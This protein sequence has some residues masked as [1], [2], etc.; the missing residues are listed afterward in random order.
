[1]RGGTFDI[2]RHE[3]GCS[4][5]RFLGYAGG[6]LAAGALSSSFAAETS[7]P[8]AA[9]AKPGGATEAGRSPLIWANLL[10]LS[11]N[12]WCDRPQESN[13]PHIIAIT[14]QPYLRCDDKLWEDLTQRM[15][16]AGMNMIVIDLGDGVRYES[17]PEIAVKGAWSVERLRQELAQLRKLGLEPI[18][19]LNFSTAHDAWLGVYS[20]QVSS[21]PYYKACEELIDEVIRLFDKPRFF[22][23]G[24]DEE[25]AG[26][27]SQYA[28]MI[29]RQH[30]LWW[31]D[32]DF[33]VKQ[34]EKRGARPWIWS[35]YIW[36]HAKDF[37]KQMPKSVLQSNW[38]YDVDFKEGSDLF[39]SY[40]QWFGKLDRSGYDQIPAGSNW[41]S[42]KSFG[43]LVE[44]CQKTIA[45][46]HL[47]GFLQTPWHPTLE[48]YRQQHIEAIDQV[49][50]AI[51]AYGKQ[52]R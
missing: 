30:E 23:L 51:A 39:K 47:K 24:Y 37:L 9:A 4:R 43:M 22:H 12:M 40:V 20:R 52:A 27:Q 17:H 28:Y 33:F 29:V 34:V 19:K 31:H 18:P 3:K 38:Y 35:D 21:P 44:Y 25:T 15:S 46:S 5:R 11:Y 13:D 48:K 8:N 49:A 1:M 42:P 16:D 41:V 7:P 32:F 50:A 14:Q 6:A 10:H 2:E 26:H 45:P 36:K